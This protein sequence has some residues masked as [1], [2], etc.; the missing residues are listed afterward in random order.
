MARPASI[1]II[2]ITDN[3]ADTDDWQDIHNEGDPVF[4][5]DFGEWNRRRCLIWTRL[6]FGTGGPRDRLRV[7]PGT[8]QR[9]NLFGGSRS[10]TYGTFQQ[11]ATLW[12]PPVRQI[13]PSNA[14]ATGREM[15]PRENFNVSM[16]GTGDGSTH[17]RGGPF[18][19]S[20]SLKG[21]NVG[22]TGTGDGSTRERGISISS[23]RSD[24]DSGDS[25]EVQ[26][27]TKPSTGT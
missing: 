17:A 26:V 24:E 13:Q 19:G 3:L 16:T 15:P 23:S 5:V 22:T 1:Y 14:P 6:D 20:R 11:P 7:G 18:S 12:K 21:S 8:A 4:R 2:G 9:P 27:V 25:A 10:T